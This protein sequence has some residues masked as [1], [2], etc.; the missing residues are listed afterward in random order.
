[1]RQ[2]RTRLPPIA[3]LSFRA[4]ARNRQLVGILA[5]GVLP[6]ALGVW[7]AFLPVL[8]DSVAWLAVL[9]TLALV[10]IQGA[11]LWMTLDRPD[12]TGP[13]LLAL[14]E[15]E[16]ERDAITIE[17]REL[18]T[19][20]GRLA[21]LQ[22]YALTLQT[23]AAQAPAEPVRALLDQMLGPL[24]EQVDRLFGFG[25]DDIWSVAVYLH[26][27]EAGLLR[28]IWRRAD[29][30]HPSL[31]KPPRAWRPGE[32]HVGQ[33]FAKIDGGA[34]LFTPDATLP[35]LRALLEATGEKQRAYDAHAYR[36]FASFT[37]GRP[38]RP[39]MPLGVVIGT[40]SEAGALDEENALPL[41]HVAAALTSLHVMFTPDA[42]FDWQNAADSLK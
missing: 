8:F 7:G 35:S 12:T 15:S 5:S 1:M 39:F 26:E 25:A 42:G 6:A 40:S 3:A 22:G 10:A 33:T 20:I 30:R 21:G 4:D 17:A 19:R 36:S 41:R 34:G 38:S 37:F 2:G 11:L 28:C 16:R 9:G 24:C 18:T 29:P 14:D 13:L 27:P 23:L 31:G 32:G